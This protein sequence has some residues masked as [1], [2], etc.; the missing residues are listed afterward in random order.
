[1]RR[2]SLILSGTLGADGSTHYQFTGPGGLGA[3]A[4]PVIYLA[5]GQNYEFVNNMGWLIHLKFVLQMVDL[6]ILNGCN[7]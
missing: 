5:R 4:D 6:S 7:K 2:T 1:M 3:T